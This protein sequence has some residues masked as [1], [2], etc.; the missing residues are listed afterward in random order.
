MSNISEK[1]FQ[2]FWSWRDFLCHSKSAPFL[3][4][5]VKYDRYYQGAFPKKWKI[6]LRDDF[7]SFFHVF[8]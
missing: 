5:V 3:F 1:L 4:C 2:A 8:L 6:R 7:F